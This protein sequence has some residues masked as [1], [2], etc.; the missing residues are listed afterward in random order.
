MID[1][2]IYVKDAEKELN[3]IKIPFIITLDKELVFELYSKAA[4][5][6]LFLKDKESAENII[7]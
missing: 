1:P 4:Y 3:K 5:G 6:Y 7:Y 2:S